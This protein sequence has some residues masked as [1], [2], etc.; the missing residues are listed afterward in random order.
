MAGSEQH[1]IRNARPDLLHGAVYCLIHAPDTPSAALATLR[2]LVASI[3]ARPLL[4][5]ASAHDASVA[6]IS[7]LPFLLSTAL[8]QLTTSAASWPELSRIA[9]T[10]YRDMTRLASGDPAMHRDI[11]LTNAAAIRP[12]LH[13]MASLLNEIAANLDDPAYL[14]Q[15]LGSAQQRRNHWLDQRN[16]DATVAAASALAPCDAQP[17]DA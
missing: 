2:R 3:G 17:S 9:A 6:A 10:G 11:C 15:L 4:M 13:D 7:H 1:G 5:P 14:D 8:V 12:W 16:S